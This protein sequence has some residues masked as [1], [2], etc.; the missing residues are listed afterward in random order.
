MKPKILSRRDIAKFE[1]YLRQLEKSENTVEKYIRDVNS[2]FGFAGEKRVTKDL[3]IAYKS[4]LI[5]ENYAAPSVNSIL[6]SVNSLL[7][8]LGWSNCKVKTIKTQKQIYCPEEKELTKFEY[9]RLVS[10]AQR[11]GNERL[12]LILQTICCTEFV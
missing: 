10:A 4:K 2:F 3:V 12:S 11:Q 1:C 7:C 8:F 9:E 5:S 6:A